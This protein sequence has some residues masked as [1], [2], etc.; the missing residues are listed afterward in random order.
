MLS[1][2]ICC[3]VTST[4]EDLEDLFVLNFFVRLLAI[5]QELPDEDAK[6]P[7]VVL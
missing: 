6:G 4:E 3:D 2:K 7:E 5:R 1:L